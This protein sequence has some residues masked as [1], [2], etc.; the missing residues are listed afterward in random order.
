MIH[1]TKYIQLI[2]L[3]RNVKKT[4]IFVLQKSLHY[5]IWMK[6]HNHQTIT[7]LPFIPVR[8]YAIYLTTA[9]RHKDGVV[10]RRVVYIP[11]GGLFG[12]VYKTICVTTTTSPPYVWD[13][14]HN[15]CFYRNVDLMEA[16]CCYISYHL[17]AT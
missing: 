2:L 5:C 10:K 7:Y 6:A 9:M 14:S 15:E 12:K 3:F 16:T 11:W 4:T 17:F 1:K 13:S 8:Q